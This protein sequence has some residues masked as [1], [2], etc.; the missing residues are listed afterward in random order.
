[1]QRPTPASI[2]K[3]INADACIAYGDA[4]GWHRSG[5]GGYFCIHTVREVKVRDF[6]ALAAKGLALGDPR[7][8]PRGFGGIG[9]GG[10]W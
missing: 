1:M 7:R 8:Q 5:D 6:N 2:R 9:G 3:R 10:P 4:E